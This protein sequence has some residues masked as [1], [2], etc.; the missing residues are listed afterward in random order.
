[1]F[2]LKLTLKW[3]IYVD[4]QNLA[5]SY[6]MLFYD[7]IK[8]YIVP[9]STYAYQKAFCD[10]KIISFQQDFLNNESYNNGYF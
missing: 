9:I 4:W 5:A 3:F 6:M 10:F 2:T 8:L 7:E 1:M